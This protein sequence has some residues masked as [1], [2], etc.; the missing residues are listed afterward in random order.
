MV[1]VST[2]AIIAAIGE[3]PTGFRNYKWGARPR[4]DL[5]KYAGPTDE[6]LTTYIP[7][8]KSEPMFDI[9]VAEENYGFVHGRFYEGNVYVDGGPNFQKMKIAVISKFGSPT[10]T[11]ERLRIYRWKWPKHKIEVVLSYQAKFAK[12]TVTFTNSAI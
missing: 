11:N 2:T 8:T 7:T 6:G 9:P 4:G 3:P 1:L 12:T 5:K 10:F